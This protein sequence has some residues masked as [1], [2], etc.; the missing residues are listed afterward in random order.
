MWS[1]HK[2]I[3]LNFICKSVEQSSKR[4][5]LPKYTIVRYEY[6]AKL[7]KEIWLFAVH[8]THC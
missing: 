6:I 4:S 3:A 7:L 1:V 2:D 8:T 5:R